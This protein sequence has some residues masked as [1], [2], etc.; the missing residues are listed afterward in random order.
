MPDTRKPRRTKVGR[1]TSNKMNKTV[2]VAVELVTRHRLYGRTLRRTRNF[3][4]HDEADRAAARRVRCPTLM[5]WSERDDMELLYGD[6]L[7]I[8]RNW[9]D[10]L[11]GG[12]IDCGHHMAEEA[13][14]QLA[15]KLLH[16]LRARR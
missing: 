14:D 11:D 12:S 5:L 1:V 7:A 15:A 3:K 13:P 16:W 10:E 9:T 8:W 6:P 4:A 2:V